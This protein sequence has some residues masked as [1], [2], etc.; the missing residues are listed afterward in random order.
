MTVASILAVSMSFGL[1]VCFRFH[2][3]E[4]IGYLFILCHISLSIFL[5]GPVNFANRKLFC[6]LYA[7]H[8]ILFLGHL[9][10][11][12]KTPVLGGVCGVCVCSPKGTI[13]SSLLCSY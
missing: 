10:E 9:L 7:L 2:I 5:Q 4:V 13:V 11:V 8:T 6:S 3:Y 12:V 1:F